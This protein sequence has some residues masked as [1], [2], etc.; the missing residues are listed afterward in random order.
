MIYI[1]LS[2]TVCYED[3]DDFFMFEYVTAVV[4][5]RHFHFNILRSLSFWQWRDDS[6]QYKTCSDP[7][8]YVCQGHDMISI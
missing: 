7:L 1:A 6:Y 4:P 3:K 8:H 5:H 2:L